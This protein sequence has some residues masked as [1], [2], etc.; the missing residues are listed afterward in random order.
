[1]NLLDEILA[2]KRASLALRQS[3]ASL[4]E[5]KARIADC[6]VTRGFHR[7][8]VAVDRPVAL[9]A[10]IK[11]GSPSR[12][13]IRKDLDPA[14]MARSF[15][16]AG[17]HCLSVLTDEKYFRASSSHLLFAR[18]AV[19]L[20]CLRKDFV[21]DEY[22]VWEARSM[23]A[24]AILLIVNGLDDVSLRDFR[25]IAEGL[26]MDALVEIHSEPEAARAIRSGASLIG[27]NNRDLESFETSVAVG[28][29]LLPTLVGKGL[30][31]VS[32]SALTSFS[33]VQTV[34]AAGATAV[35]IGTAFC[36]ADDPGAKVREVM[37]W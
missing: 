7:S 29:R 22:D 25:E 12:G 19:G 27:V 34:S 23:G 16:E 5:L 33:D 18:G 9:I 28:E 20:P 14:E 11:P 30:T 1:M 6:D 31:L 35:L 24:D 32:E 37:G 15:E 4:V 26:G 8:L 10:E 36:E 13:T 3:L 2:S 17:A 21:V